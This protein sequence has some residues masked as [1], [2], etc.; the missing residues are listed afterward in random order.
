MQ[1]RVIKLELWNRL[2]GQEDY[3]KAAIKWGTDYLLKAHASDMLM[4]AQVTET[5]LHH[6]DI[7]FENRL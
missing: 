4:Y 1:N 7:E 5:I 2:P 6:V 3:A